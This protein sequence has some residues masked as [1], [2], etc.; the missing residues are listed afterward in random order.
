MIRNRVIPI[1]LLKNKGLYKTFKF[2]D[3]KYVGDPVNA[4]KIFNDIMV[5]ELVFLDITASKEKR[6]PNMVV[7]RDIASEWFMPLCYGGSVNSVEM[8]REIL[9]VRVEKVCLNTNAVKNPMLIKD[10]AN[11]FGSST[12]VVSV[13]VKK[14]LFG[15]YSVYINGGEEKTNLNPVDWALKIEE[16]GAGEIILNSIDRDGTMLGYDIPLLHSVTSKVNIPVVAAGGASS[17]ND[18]SMALKEANVAAVAAGAFFV[19]HGKHRAVLISYPNESEIDELM[20][21]IKN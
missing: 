9:N 5:D 20:A 15:K 14:N 19:F 12:I 11:F 4:I 21:N 6:S 2:K 17:M 10:A 1:L 13:D 7:I 16:L 3:T 8:I 18:F